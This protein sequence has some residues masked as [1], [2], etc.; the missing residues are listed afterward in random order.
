MSDVPKFS[1]VMPTYNRAFCIKRSI[2]SLLAQ[3]GSNVEL[4]V[5]DDGSTDG[6]EAL[7]AETYAKELAQ[8]VIRYVKTENG[9]V[10]KARNVGLSMVRGEWIA[11]LDSD[12]EIVPDFVATFEKAIDEHPEAEA[13]YCK[14]EFMTSKRV[15]GRPFDFE[16]LRFHNFIDL[17]TYIHRRALCQAEGVF[18]ENMTR[19]VDWEL[20]VRYSARHTP[21]FI[22]KVVLKYDD[23][24]DTNRIT[25]LGRSSYYVNLNYLRRKHCSDYPLVTTIVTT[26]NHERFIAQALDSAVAQEGR[27]IHEILVSDDC[28][29]DGTHD[30]VRTYVEKNP[31]LVFDISGSEN[32]GISENMRKCFDAAKGKYVAMLE[33]DD[34]WCSSGKLRAQVAFLEANPDCPMVFC[35]LKLLSA[36]GLVSCG[37]RYDALSE[38]VTGADFFKPPSFMGVIG[39]FS[40]C[41]FRTALIKN[42]PESL[43]KYRL[44]EIALAF[45]LERNGAIGFLRDEFTVYRQH[46]GGVWSGAGKFGQFLQRIRCREQTKAVCREEYVPLID[47][48]IRETESSF[49]H[50]FSNAVSMCHKFEKRALESD[51]KVA[52][53]RKRLDAVEGKNKRLAQQAQSGQKRSQ[54][55]QARVATLEKEVAALVRS[56]AYRT[57]MFV[58][59]PARKAWGGVKCLRENGFKYTAKHFVG[60]VVRLFGVKVSW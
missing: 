11:Y 27:F 44:S 24:K 39:N 49:Q 32:L 21:V 34:Y 19:L 53:L 23:S 22:D 29:T 46:A 2:G 37:H 26:Y 17:G 38:R 58:T 36:K 5:V 12:N 50:Y 60:K 28:S 48:D 18:D 14:L 8:G 33:G 1:F 15:I 51:R 41:M 6:T 59:W 52:E 40:T 55:L 9:G 13:F 31:G 42:L 16:D 35:A 57:G 56:E 10:C 7:V 3:A 20:I 43:Y 54:G 45:H 30:V 4:I 25:N 47:A